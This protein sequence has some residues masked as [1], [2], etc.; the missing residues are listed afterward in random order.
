MEDLCGDGTVAGDH[1]RNFSGAHVLAGNYFAQPQI[2]TRKGRQMP[3]ASHG[4]ADPRL[5]HQL[6]QLRTALDDLL[7]TVGLARLGHVL[8]RQGNE[9]HHL[10]LLGVARQHDPNRLRRLLARKFE[11]LRAVHSRHTHVG[12]DY[13]VRLRLELLDCERGICDKRH[14]PFRAGAIQ[15]AAQALEKCRLIV[16]EQD[17]LHDL[18]PDA[19]PPIGKRSIMRVPRPTK[20]S[21][22]SVPPCFSTTIERA[23][24]RP[25]P[26][27]LPTS[28]V[29][30]KGSK[31]RSRF[32]GGMP[33]PLSSNA[34]SIHRSPCVVQMRIS[35][36]LAS[37]PAA[38]MACAALTMRL[39][40]T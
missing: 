33:Q 3:N 24:A 16:N 5:L 2:G 12:Y 37:R 39:R 13:I 8:M 27:P 29:V 23:I 38:S 30:K 7:E 18:P 10:P 9:A 32:S 25:C 14:L 20:L 36:V 19:R 1:F 31:I 26:V 6:L 15:T 28:L 22:A 35:P 34:I 40:K 11:Q 21:A 17:L 4:G